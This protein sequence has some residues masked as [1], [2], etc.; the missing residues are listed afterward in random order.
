M[1]NDNI[2]LH[3]FVMTAWQHYLGGISVNYIVDLLNKLFRFKI[4]PGGLTQGWLRLANL[5]HSEYEKIG[6]EAW[7]SAVL[8]ADETGWRQSGDLR[9]LWCFTNKK[10]CYYLIAKTRASSVVLKFLRRCFKGTLICD[11]LKVYDKLKALAKQ[12]CF[13]HLF[14]ELLKVEARNFCQEWKLFQRRLTSLL[15][16][17][18]RLL[19]KKAELP[20]DLL[21]RK[22]GNLYYQLNWLIE[23]DYTDKDCKRLRN[24]LQRYREELF[25]FLERDDV[26]PYNNH[27]EQ[28]MRKPVLWR[29]RCQQN[30]S[31]KGV[32]AQAILMTVFRTAE[33]QGLNPVDYIEKLVKEQIAKNH[34]KTKSAKKAA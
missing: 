21:R 6:N 27:A 12:R 11:F 25:T 31:D 9:W 29:R 23:Q 33:L 3:T 1:P 15:K 14:A 7:K 30:R 16:D 32:E 19:E 24:R 13:F 18:V 10:L 26:S 17:A 4:S 22:K 34:I 28:Q 8:H 20:P 5:L 2:G